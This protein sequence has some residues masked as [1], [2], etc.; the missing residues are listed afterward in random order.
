MGAK[1]VL[2]KRGVRSCWSFLGTKGRKTL[3]LLVHMDERL[4]HAKAPVVQPELEPSPCMVFSVAS[5]GC[6]HPRRRVNASPQSPPKC[7]GPDATRLSQRVGDLGLPTHRLQGCEHCSE[8]VPVSPP[9][10]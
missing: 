4:S 7:F 6:A 1:G 10:R 3:M 9:Q 5:F 2:R 8:G